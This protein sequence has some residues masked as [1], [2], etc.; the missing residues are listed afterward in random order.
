MSKYGIRA[1][2]AAA[3]L[4]CALATMPANAVP[5]TFNFAD[6]AGNRSEGSS[7][8]VT[9][10]GL[11]TTVTA[12]GGNVNVNGNRG[13]GVTGNPGGNRVA[14]FTDGSVQEA[15]FFSFAPTAVGLLDS[16][17]FE[18][19]GSGPSTFELFVDGA[20]GGQFTIG[21]GSSNATET[22]DFSLL[23]LSGMHFEFRA[24]HGNGFRVTS[25]SVNRLQVPEPHVLLLGLT[26]LLAFR[27]GRRRSR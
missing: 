15:L 24:I 27:L 19:G 6:G 25:M 26:G 12:L 1:L 20:T 9:E 5:I 16:V 17:L 3:A 2:G 23:N 21:G 13:L 8:T 7:L 14:A 4:L 10:H 18:R 11:T 22:V